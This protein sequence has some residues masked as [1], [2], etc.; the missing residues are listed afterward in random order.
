MLMLAVLAFIYCVALL[1]MQF[2]NAAIYFGIGIFV[3][4]CLAKRGYGALTAYGS[5]RWANA[6]DLRKAGMLGAKTGLIIGR[7]SEGGNQ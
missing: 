4:A 7:V 2:E 5:A 3:L 1:A 6:S